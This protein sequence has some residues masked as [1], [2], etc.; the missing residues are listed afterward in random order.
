MQAP[1]VDG[2]LLDLGVDRMILPL[3][4]AGKDEVIVALNAHAEAIA[5]YVD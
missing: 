5:A 3:P 4:Q 2:G 1:G